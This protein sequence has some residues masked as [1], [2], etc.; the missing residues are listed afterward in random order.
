MNKPAPKEPSMDEI[1]SSIRQIIADDDAGSRKVTP[2]E[3]AMPAPVA[4]TPFR[5]VAPASDP[6]PLEPIAL[7]VDQIVADDDDAA[8]TDAGENFD[9]DDSE[10]LASEGESALISEAFA[11]ADLVEPDDVT[12]EHAESAASEPVAPSEAEPVPAMSSPPRAALRPSAP[13]GRTAPMP[14]P[15]LSNEIAAQLLQPA[16]NAAVRH[17]FARLG[18]LAVATPGVTLE[19]MMRDMLRPLLKDWLDENLPTVVERM[20]EKEITRISRGGD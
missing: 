19:D 12:F 11:G 10:D 7:S 17:T 9:G 14:D 20:V 8:A 2:A 4:V 5:S 16:T 3:T 1:L 6:A 18:N 15:D 13:V